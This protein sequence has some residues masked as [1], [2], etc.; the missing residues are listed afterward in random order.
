MCDSTVLKVKLKRLNNAQSDLLHQ[1]LFWFYGNL[2]VFSISIGYVGPAYGLNFLYSTIAGISGLA[3]GTIFM[4]LHAIQGPVTKLSQMVQSRYQFGIYGNLLPSLSA[5]VMFSSFALL[6]CIFISDGIR[7]IYHVDGYYTFLFTIAMAA[8]LAVNGHLVIIRLFKYLTILSLPLLC[9]FT[10]YIFTHSFG[11]HSP[12]RFSFV[13]FIIT[14][15]VAASFNITFSPYVS[16]YTREVSEDVGATRLGLTVFFGAFLSAA[17]LLIIGAW[18]SHNGLSKNPI[19]DIYKLGNSLYNGYGTLLLLIF[20]ISLIGNVSINIYSGATT[21][22]SS[23]S[24]VCI[25][26]YSLRKRLEVIALIIISTLVFCVWLLTIN[27]S[28]I[29]LV[30]S[31]LTLLIYLLCPWTAINLVDFYLKNGDYSSEDI[32]SVAIVK[33]PGSLS[34]ILGLFIGLL[35][36]NASPFFVGPFASN[37]LLSSLGWLFGLFS[38]GL[39]YFIL[40]KKDFLL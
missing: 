33:V 5:L 25:D 37:Q 6:N 9:V 14:F 3:F 32:T 17:W 31:L 8:F 16:D 11:L 29:G 7:K 38:S 18:L 1:L 2:Q 23:V 24:T 34:F 19:Y 22:V 15:S 4:A 20:S 26:N 13:S 35:F 40:S 36:I 27:I 10:V 30:S 12:T 28:V 21:L 39:F